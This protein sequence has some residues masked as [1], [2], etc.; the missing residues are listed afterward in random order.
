[1]SQENASHFLDRNP[2]RSLLRLPQAYL[3]QA[4]ALAYR[5]YQSESYAQAEVM[6][7]G[8]LAADHTYWWAYSLHAAVLLKMGR[9]HEALAQIDLGLRYEPGHPKLLAMKTDILTAA[10]LLGSAAQ[11]NAA[12]AKDVT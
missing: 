2:L 10:A 9:P 1:M 8:L 5:L 11:A 3:D 12:G 4:M 6:C 7:R